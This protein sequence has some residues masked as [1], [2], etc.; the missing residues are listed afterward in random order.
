M[1]Y[2]STPFEDAPGVIDAIIIPDEEK[3]KIYSAANS[4]MKTLAEKDASFVMEKYIQRELYSKQLEYMGRYPEV[5][6]QALIP[7]FQDL[8]RQVS[9]YNRIYNRDALEAVQSL[10]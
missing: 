6:R 5:L 8:P 9:V 2:S 1:L 3:D 10:L 7:Y 4:R